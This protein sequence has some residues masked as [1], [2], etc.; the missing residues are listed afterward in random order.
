MLL[1]TTTVCLALI[2]S[3]SP[4]ASANVRTSGHSSPPTTEPLRPAAVLHHAIPYGYQPDPNPPASSKPIGDGIDVNF[5]R[6]VRQRNTQEILKQEIEEKFVSLYH[7]EVSLAAKCVS[8]D[9]GDKEWKDPLP[10]PFDENTTDPVALADHKLREIVQD[11]VE[12]RK[13]TFHTDQLSDDLISG[14]AVVHD[15]PV[16]GVVLNEEDKKSIDNQTTID[17]LAENIK[18]PGSEELDGLEIGKKIAMN[19]S[20]EVET[21][22]N[23]ARLRDA[24]NVLDV[25][26][27]EQ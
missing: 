5:A 15:A 14:V 4:A 19:V 8:S 21:Q 22:Q 23:E 18:P 17:L 11:A 7:H 13:K 10:I 9:P 20:G 24:N 1:R 12:K 2:S 25:V 6:R 3:F 26:E 27:V 16:T